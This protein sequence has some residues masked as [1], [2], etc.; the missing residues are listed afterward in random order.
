MCEYCKD[1]NRKPFK[2]IDLNYKKEKII[3]NKRTQSIKIE[4]SANKSFQTNAFGYFPEVKRFE[5]TITLPI[6]F[7]PM[8]GEKLA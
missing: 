6:K 8:C 5:D 4:I 2:N 3:L 7:C 1:K